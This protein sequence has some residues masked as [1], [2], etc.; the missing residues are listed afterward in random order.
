VAF[1]RHNL[2][3]RDW[4][5]EWGDELGERHCTSRKSFDNIVSLETH[6][7][8]RYNIRSPHC[9]VPNPLGSRYPGTQ[10]ELDSDLSQN[11]C[12]GTYH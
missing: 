1:Y 5:D 9:M 11:L 7:V 10:R 6:T 4:G 12:T 2:M 8:H 3:F